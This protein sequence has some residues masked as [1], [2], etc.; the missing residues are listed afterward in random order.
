MGWRYILRIESVRREQG[1]MTRDN[2]R[3]DGAA[4][5]SWANQSLGILGRG[6]TPFDRKSWKITPV[7]MLRTECRKPREETKVMRGGGLA[8]W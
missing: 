4:L 8:W 5:C 6:V 1:N 2:A 7:S 3:G